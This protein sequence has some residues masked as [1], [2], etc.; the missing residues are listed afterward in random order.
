MK[1]KFILLSAYDARKSFVECAISDKCSGKYAIIVYIVNV[2]IIFSGIECWDLKAK[3][4]Q[5]L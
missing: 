4:T 5:Q 3:K 2:L 1:F